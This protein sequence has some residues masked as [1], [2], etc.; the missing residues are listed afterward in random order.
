MKECSV[1]CDFTSICKHRQIVL[2]SGHFLWC[3]F[4]KT[5]QMQWAEYVIIIIYIYHS[6][7]LFTHYVCGNCAI[8]FFNSAMNL[9]GLD[10]V[11]WSN[12]NFLKNIWLL[13]FFRSLLFIKLSIYSVIVVITN[14]LLSVLRAR[15][16]KYINTILTNNLFKKVI[17]LERTYFD[18]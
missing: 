8:C 9:D 5:N 3:V 18:L 10:G 4:V 14:S 6:I 12:I 17:R 13:M 1:K 15:T 7:C 11:N 16:T 2:K